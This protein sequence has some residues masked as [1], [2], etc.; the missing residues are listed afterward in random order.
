MGTIEKRGTNS[1]RVGERLSTEQGRD[2]IRRPLKFP[3]TMSEAEQRRAA[4][5][6]LARIKIEIDQG[7]AAPQQE[8]TVRALAEIWLT[9]HVDHFE[10]KSLHG[11]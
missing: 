10:G 8:L 1:W 2:W 11:G 7:Q 3:P 5:V 6:E 9:E 4:E